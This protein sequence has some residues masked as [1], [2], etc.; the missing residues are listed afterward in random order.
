MF[1]WRKEILP[2]LC[3]RMSVHLTRQGIRQCPQCRGQT[4]FTKVQSI[5]KNALSSSRS[6]LVDGNIGEKHSS[7]V[8]NRVV[9][10]E[11]RALG[12]TMANACRCRCTPTYLGLAKHVGPIQDKRGGATLGSTFVRFPRSFRPITPYNENMSERP[13]LSSSSSPAAYCRWMPSR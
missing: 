5:S 1:V 10:E 6:T 4:F 7:C 8:N 3:Y 12:I 2:E 13:N 11:F 9:H